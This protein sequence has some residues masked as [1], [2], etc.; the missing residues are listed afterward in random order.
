MLFGDR[1]I[2]EDR[3]GPRGPPFFVLL[4]KER[5]GVRCAAG[6]GKQ[7]GRLEVLWI[8]LGCRGLKVWAQLFANLANCEWVNALMGD[9]VFLT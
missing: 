8:E 4:E 2:V 6:I 5:G 1:I 7:R 9:F 3:A